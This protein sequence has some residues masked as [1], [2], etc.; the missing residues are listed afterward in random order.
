MTKGKVRP[1]AVAAHSSGEASPGTGG[2]GLR[3][4]A[5][6]AGS[7]R[8]R[9]E[10][11]AVWD[12]TERRH[13]DRRHEARQG[14]HFE[15]L[16]AELSSRFVN[17]PPD[18][19]DREIEGGQQRICDALGLEIATLWQL[20]EDPPGA[21]RLTHLY[22]PLGG[23]PLPDQMTAG[24]YFP[25]IQEQVV[26]GK[27]VAISSPDELP[28]AAA[29][30]RETLRHYGVKAS[31]N[32]PLSAGG[33]GVIGVQSFNTV[34][35]ERTWPDPIVSRLRLIA[36]I[37]ANALVRKRTDQALRE[38]EARLRLA[39]ESAEVGLWM[40]D[41]TTRRFWVS[42]VARELFGYAPDT[43]VTLARVLESVHP[44][45]RNR[46]SEAVGSALETERTTNVEYRIVRPDGSVRWLITRGRAHGGSSG[47]PARL[48]GTSADITARKSEEARRR[49]HEHKLAAAI[50]VAGLG[51]YE[52]RG[53]ADL[54]YLDERTR[55]ILGV[56]EAQADRG[57][58]FWIERLHPDDRERVLGL[59]RQ[60][61][62]GELNSVSVTYRY[63]HPERG[64]VW[65]HHVSHVLE[66]DTRRAA[67]LVVGVLRDVTEQR[68][69][70]E[71]AAKAQAQILAVM[72]STKDLIWSVDP[73][74]HG[75]LTWNKGLK[76]HFLRSDIEVALGKTPE[77]LLPPDF[78]VRWHEMYARALQEGFFTTEYTVVTGRTILLL[79][80]QPMKRD[81][82]VFAISVFGKDIT[83]LKH[84]EE[85]LRQSFEEVKRLKSRLEMENKYLLEEHRLKFGRGLIVGESTAI[86][87]VLA[88]VEQVAGARTTVLIEGE[89]GVGKEL[90]ARRIHELSPRAERPLVKV[91]C[92]ALP[93]TLVESE[94]FGREKGAYTGS[95]SRELGRFELA[96]GSTI[97]LDEVSE[98]PLE[99]QGKLL[100]GLE[101]GPFERLGSPRT[102][103]TDARV[104]A[105]TNRRL[106]EEVKAGR[107][108]QDL[109]YR[110]SAFPI[111]VP[112]LRERREDIPLIAWAIVEELAAAM[113]REVESIPRRVMEALKAYS[114]PGNVRELRNVIER[115][116]ILSSGPTLF[117]E[118][119]GGVGVAEAAEEADGASLDEAQRRHI[120]KVLKSVRGRISGPGGAAE[121][122]GLRPSTLRSRM[123]RLGMDP[124]RGNSSD[125]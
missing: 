110:I 118:L 3:E 1:G 39:T 40:M 125:V 82:E 27:T 43:E 79:S 51:F 30:D 21:L 42:D 122:L 68:R 89:T 29:R 11:S 44:E 46:V 59:S 32:F 99:L 93:S 73:E 62:G 64:T 117:I 123:I 26:A 96:N 114:W 10:P 47:Q 104:I 6:S 7:Q 94:L 19:V 72:N 33:V 109:Y 112:P 8:V 35:E 106:E 17:L 101:H 76:D 34:R 57:R 91:N 92:A 13:G 60:L 111:R 67:S 55:F 20:V 53:G 105:A 83:E 97:F 69:S 24:E 50:D 2:N 9:H 65:L 71:A 124:H 119:P 61:L 90:V 115:A 63:L 85:A 95:V 107:F 108:R 58:A 4:G 14:V 23:P 102:L 77:E 31:V 103:H 116:M 86:G 48:L 70:E 28:P 98:L 87:K 66:R 121:L 15:T 49:E 75:L 25:W 12:G 38:S 16:I 74:R 56:P 5:T 120:Q 37:F 80:I 18:E 113:N 84:S 88:E 100:H 22:R 78:A 52:L 54:A 41:I 45:D 36:H 81:G